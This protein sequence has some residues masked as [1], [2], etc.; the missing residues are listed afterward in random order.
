MDHELGWDDMAIRIL[1]ADDHLMVRD[2]LAAMLT[3]EPGIEMVALA[4]DGREAVDRAVALSPDVALLDVSMPELNGIE[5][6]RQI[7]QLVPQCRVIALSALGELCFVKQM[8]A[9][10]AS[11]YVSK[12]ESAVRLVQTIR[13]VYA[14]ESCLAPN[15]ASSVGSGRV[16][17]SRREREVLRNI[18]C[19]RRG[20]EI[21]AALGV[22]VKTVD[23][24]RR[25]IMQKLGLQS[26]AEL[27]RYAV[28]L[29]GELR[30]ETALS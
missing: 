21:A 19:G 1:L 12:S 20:S 9:A 15:L 2:A 7:R 13:Q 24:Y 11:G 3:A 22:K 28:I 26:Q 18:G 30:A 27:M 5:A 25:R 23:T 16:L 29:G 10:G 17:L 6:A 8:A 14:G 4:C